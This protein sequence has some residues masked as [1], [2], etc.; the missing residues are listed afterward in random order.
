MSFINPKTKQVNC[1]IVYFGPAL[2]GKST[3]LR[4]L[5][6]HFAKKKKGQIVS[7][8]GTQDQTAFFDFL[9]LS[10]GKINQQEIRIHLYAIPGPI[11]HETSRRLLMKG[12]DGVIFVADSRL[13]RLE[14]NIACLQDL[15]DTLRKQNTFLE[16]LPFVFQYNKRD[17][18]KEIAPVDMLNE[19]LN[20]DQRPAF[21]T[22]ASK[23]TSV[24]EP[25]ETITRQVLQELHYPE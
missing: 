11:L 14:E 18:A 13:A 3:T 1:K 16:E 5:H 12:I 25:L 22:V 21:E 7:L 23:G 4:R 15:E 20:P 17:L 6:R 9:P 24:V 2:S 19:V 10:L 8:G